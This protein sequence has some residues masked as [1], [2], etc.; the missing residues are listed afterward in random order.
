MTGRAPSMQIALIRGINVGGRKKMAMAD[1]RRLLEE[2]GFGDVRSLLQSGNLIFK[3]D[4]RSPTEVERLLEAESA[5]RFGLQADVFVRTAE[6]WN[7]IVSANP[8]RR[9]ARSDPQ[10]LVVMCTRDALDPRDVT[11]LQAAITGPEVIRANG[12]Q[13]Y[14]VYPAG[15][16]TS[17]LTN[18]TVEKALETR[19]TARNW[20]TALRLHTFTKAPD[21]GK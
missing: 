15:I 8:F 17:R 5:A 19:G 1:L 14:M 21:D 12:R 11:R 7:D 9:E 6:E 2:L 20:N 16:G 13:L 3:A 10:H 4:R 18:A